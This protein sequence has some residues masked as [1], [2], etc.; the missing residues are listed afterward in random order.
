[1]KGSIRCG[2]EKTDPGQGKNQYPGNLVIEG[3]A[4]GTRK[5]ISNL[6]KARGGEEEPARTHAELQRLYASKNLFD[7]GSKQRSMGGKKEVLDEK[8]DKTTL[9]IIKR[10]CARGRTPLTSQT[11]EQETMLKRRGPLK[12]KETV[13]PGGTESERK[14]GT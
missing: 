11:P 2:R 7:K 13:L 5:I 3:V 8:G 4:S 9:L 10:M 6:G 14:K 1:M 12:K